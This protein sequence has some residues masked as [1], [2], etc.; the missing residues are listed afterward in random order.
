MREVTV[1][2]DNKT[3]TA[4]GGCRWEDVDAALAKYGLAAV[5]G[6]VNDTGIGGLTLGG[7][8]GWLTSQYGLVIDNLLEVEIVLVDGSVVWASETVNEE[9]FFGI[10]GAGVNFGVVTK[11]TYKAYDREFISTPF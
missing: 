10:R 9:L 7:G 8:Y 2:A 11:F 6:T 4:Q 3:V 5:G 1:D